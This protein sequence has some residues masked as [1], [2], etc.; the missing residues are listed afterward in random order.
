[1][2]DGPIIVP[3]INSTSYVLS[4]DTLPHIVEYISENG[5]YM[6]SNGIIV[7]AEEDV[8]DY[9]NGNLHIDNISMNG[10]NEIN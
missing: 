1:M 10:A 9:L 3:G 7:L 2:V 6:L 5:S 8:Q 4:H